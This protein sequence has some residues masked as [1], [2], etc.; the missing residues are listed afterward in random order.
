MRI[1]DA[2]NLQLIFNPA[3]FHANLLPAFLDKFER[4]LLNNLLC[5]IERVRSNLPIG[6][7]HLIFGVA[8]GSRD[9][10]FAP[11]R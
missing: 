3:K 1:F 5:N 8:A 4:T 7:A 10:F 6:L 2:T 11:P 9:L